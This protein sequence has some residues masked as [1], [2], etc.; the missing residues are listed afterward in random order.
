M[1]KNNKILAIILIAVMSI[2][3]LPGLFANG[4]MA[5]ES[6]TKTI[7]KNVAINKYVY[8]GDGNA[9]PTGAGQALT[10]GRRN[11]D[12]TIY[13]ADNHI[14]HKGT[15]NEY[16]GILP[17]GA[18]GVQ[19]STGASDWYMIDL[20]RKYN[21]TNV[22]LY[23]HTTYNE[24][25]AIGATSRYMSNVEVQL[26]NTEDFAQYENVIDIE[27]ATWDQFPYAESDFE[28]KR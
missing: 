16:S 10:D 5:E 17:S 21:I 9:G 19:A 28:G 11:M 15:L 1:M 13:L 22:K 25:G 14:T 27:T 23:A 6:L 8:A 24:S 3:I 12:Y 4:V 7:N 20:G 18:L 2:S 26:S